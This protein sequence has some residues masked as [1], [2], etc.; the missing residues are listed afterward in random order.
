M[1]ALSPSGRRA[2]PSTVRTAARNSSH[3]RTSS[4]ES[5]CPASEDSSVSS[6]GEEDRTTR[7]RAP[8]RDSS[9]QAR[10]KAEPSEMSE[11]SEISEVS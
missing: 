8:C 10:D 7:G 11:M 9:A 5:N 3:P 2:E 4:T 1:G 6:C